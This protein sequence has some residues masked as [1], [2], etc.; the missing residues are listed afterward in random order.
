VFLELCE[1]IFRRQIA[2]GDDALFE[3]P[4]GSAA[5][6]KRPIQNIM[7]MEGVFIGVGHGCMFG[8]KNVKTDKLVK[9]PTLWCSTSC[10]ICDEL[11]VR[12]DHNHEHGMCLGGVEITAAAGR[13][14]PAI[15]KTILRGYW[16]LQTRK[17]PG[18]LRKWC[19]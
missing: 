6:K 9:K 11:S 17:D 19:E 10:E 5:L 16:K 18:R 15:A 13:Y 1:E 2:R 3:Q 4:L 12:C 8:I 14:T 7:N